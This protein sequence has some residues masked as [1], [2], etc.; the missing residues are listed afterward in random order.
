[1][2]KGS[3]S[4]SSDGEDIQV[5][6]GF[7]DLDE[8]MGGL[9]KGDLIIM[10]AHPSMGK[11]SLSL[12]IVHNAAERG[13][14]VGVF[15]L[16]MR[17]EQLIQRLLAAETGVNRQRLNLG[18]MRDE[19]WQNV[20]DAIG[21]LA[22]MPIYIDDSAELT[23]QEISSKSRRLMAEVGVDLLVI[24]YLQLM[25]GSV[26]PDADRYQE[27]SE[28]S[29]G[30][31]VLARELNI[32]IIACVPVPRAVEYVTNYMPN[33]Q[34]LTDIGLTVEDA[35]IVMFIHRE[36]MYN[37]ETEKKGIADVHIAKHRN[38]PL[39]TIP[40]RFFNRTT[41]FADLEVYRQEE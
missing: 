24:D 6:T 29:R 38:G 39:T 32:P 30:L 2:A 25:E 27:M 28:I 4:F 20:S 35:D 3:T 37:P 34:D 12:G 41:K 1:M 26:S 13:S 36:E 7:H 22:Q 16:E 17:R 40:L 14:R 23:I 33:L 9:R 10:A 8:V 5:P 21:R 18:Y 11:T 19:E 15:S 31:K